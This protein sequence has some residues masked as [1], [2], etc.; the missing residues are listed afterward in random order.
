MRLSMV[1]GSTRSTWIRDG[2]DCP[3]RRTADGQAMSTSPSSVLRSGSDELVDV[4]QG[5]QS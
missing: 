4:E 2:G 1:I 5:A 3:D